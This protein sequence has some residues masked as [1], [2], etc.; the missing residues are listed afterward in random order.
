VTCLKVS[1]FDIGLTEGISFYS[2]LL[3]TDR[4]PSLCHNQHMAD[5]IYPVQETDA[6]QVKR[7]KEYLYRRALCELFILFIA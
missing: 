7:R 4:F 3:V 6:W 5:L 1:K 2:P